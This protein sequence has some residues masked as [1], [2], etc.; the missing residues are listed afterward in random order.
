MLPTKKLFHQKRE[1]P[2]SGHSCLYCDRWIH[3]PIIRR[4]SKGSKNKKAVRR[5]CLTA[6]KRVKHNSPSCK[7]FIP[8]K[9]IYC[10]QLGQRVNMLLCLNRRLN[11][12]QFKSWED[13][14]QCR[15]FDLE[16][17]PIIEDYH[18]G[19]K[20]II[21]KQK[22]NKKEGKR[23]LKR[24]DSKNDKKRTLKRRKPKEEK[25]KLKRRSEKDKPKRKLKRR[26]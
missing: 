15:Q 2:M 16:V 4:E 26:K 18:V 8:I 11:R 25:R 5:K 12:D 19:L 1:S 9:H 23:V 21:H 14:K 3:L 22:K 7:Y 6:K 20:K 10:D 17:Q 13:C 24:R